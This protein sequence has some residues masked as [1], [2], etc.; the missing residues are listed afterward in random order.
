MTGKTGGGGDWTARNRQ[1]LDLF[2][3]RCRPGEVAV[4]DW[5]NTCCGGDIGDAFFWHQAHRR[6][7]LPPGEELARLLDC[8]VDGQ[9]IL[10]FV[11]GPAPLAPLRERLRSERNDLFAPL[12][13]LVSALAATPG[14]GDP[15][16]YAFQAA[17]VAW[18]APAD[19]RRRA[20]EVFAAE[21]QAEERTERMIDPESGEEICWRS[22]LRPYQPMAD[23]AADLRRRGV[24]VAVV[25]ATAT[26][27]VQGAVAAAGFAADEVIGQDPTRAAQVLRG[28][29]DP[30]AGLLYGPGKVLAIRVRFARDP[31]LVAGD[32]PGDV[33]MLISF[34]ATRLR[35]LI[36]RGRSAPGAFGP[37]LDRA[38]AGDEGWLVQPADPGTGLFL[39]PRSGTPDPVSSRPWAS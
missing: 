3:E 8:A 31:V 13:R 37:L 5:D 22:G 38:R 27:V 19:V 12:V 9:R 6:E 14:L 30:V 21:L 24:E 11:S 28:E 7:C 33:P 36:D 16:A 39:D 1:T 23:L 2:L 10:H 26:P 17:L 18:G 32:S 35:L 15:V 20:G 34:P 25:S 4:F 29:L